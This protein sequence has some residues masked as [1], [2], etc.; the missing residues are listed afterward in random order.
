MWNGREWERADVTLHHARILHMSWPT[1][2]GVLLIGG[3]DSWDDFMT[4]ELVTWDGKTSTVSF[5][6]EYPLL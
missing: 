4:T 1:D 6:L 3:G 2:D 5:S